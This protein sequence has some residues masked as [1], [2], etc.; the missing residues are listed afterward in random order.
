MDIPNSRCC[1]SRPVRPENQQTVC[2]RGRNRVA[3]SD[4]TAILLFN[5]RAAELDINGIADRRRDVGTSCFAG[6]YFRG[7][8]SI[9]VVPTT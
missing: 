5:R 6:D 3:L 7:R 4:A 8:I 1:R 9:V 2:R